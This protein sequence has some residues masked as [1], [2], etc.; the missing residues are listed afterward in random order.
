MVCE[1]SVGAGPLLLRML[2]RDEQAA[3]QAD[4]AGC[5]RPRGFAWAGG[6]YGAIPPY[7]FQRAA[8]GVSIEASPS[9]AATSRMSC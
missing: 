4:P 7:W 6:E 5:G 2:P 9:I 1:P 8:A 3:S